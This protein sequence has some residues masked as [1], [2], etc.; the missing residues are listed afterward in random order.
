MGEI[1]SGLIFYLFTPPHSYLPSVC[2]SMFV[3]GYSI[4]DISGIRRVCMFVMEKLFPFP[5]NVR[6]LSGWRE[7][8]GS[9]SLRSQEHTHS[10]IPDWDESEGGE[11]R[12]NLLGFFC[13]IDLTAGRREAERD[14]QCK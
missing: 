12:R 7:I 6:T 3:M 8:D 11:K 13:S 5:S 2:V 1:I 14:L 9:S 10:R 4:F